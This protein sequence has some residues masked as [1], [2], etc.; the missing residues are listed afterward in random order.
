MIKLPED[1]L[2][3]L[4]TDLN[5]IRFNDVPIGGTLATH[6]QVVFLIGQPPPGRF[7]WFRELIRSFYIEHIGTRFVRNKKTSIPTT[8]KKG[9][10]LLT[11]ISERPHVFK[12]NYVLFQ[13]QPLS[14]FNC[15]LKNKR[16]TDLFEERP[17]ATYFDDLPFEGLSVWRKA[18][19]KIRPAIRKVI[20]KFVSENQLPQVFRRKLMNVLTAQTQRMLAFELLLKQLQPKYILTEY[21]RNDMCSGLILTA[22]KMAIPTYS[23]MHGV[24]NHRFGYLPLL[25][26]YLFCWGERQKQ[27]LID[28]GAH[29]GKLLVT[30]AT[31]LSNRLKTTKG[32]ARMKIKVSPSQ[33]VIVLATN[34]VNH[35]YR[36]QLATFFC[37][38]INNLRTFKGVVR[39]HS[40]ENLSFYQSFIDRY[41]NILFDKNTILNF[42]ESLA[43][44]DIVCIFNSAYSIDAIVKS[45]P[46]VII[47]LDDHNL[48]QAADLINEGGFPAVK[49]AQ[50]LEIFIQQYFSED[51]IH[52]EAVKNQRRYAQQYCND[53]EIDAVS[54]ILQTIQKHTS[55]SLATYE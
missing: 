16:L 13:N 4:E 52:Q 17:N 30:G 39:L 1:K 33:K 18:F 55:H 22:R 9:A 43:V 37:E 14:T 12:I 46:V 45:V 42:E 2:Q 51:G 44:A 28:K 50:E 20:A 7:T 35:Y 29:P 34:P 47:N 32:E 27:L 31:Q 19:N 36:Q 11:F 10:P 49:T 54:N 26:D 3:Q 48:G 24:V 40:S 8:L 25:A 6:L 53:F 21:D 41:P 5:Q 23:H 15:I 38:A